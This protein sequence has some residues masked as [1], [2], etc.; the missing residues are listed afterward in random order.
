MKIEKNTLIQECR[1]MDRNFI[2]PTDF[3]ELK[4]SKFI[5]LPNYEEV[6]FIQ[7]LM[8][9]NGQTQRLLEQLSNCRISIKGIMQNQQRKFQKEKAVMIQAEDEETLEKGV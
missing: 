2:V 3:K 7:M 8:G 5:Q 9:P 1:Q 6:N 4:F